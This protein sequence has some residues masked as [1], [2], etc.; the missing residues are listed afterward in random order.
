MARAKAEASHEKVGAVLEGRGRKSRE[1]NNGAPGV[2][3]TRETYWAEAETRLMEEIVRRANMQKA[4]NRVVS[5][6]GEAGV[7]S[8]S[9][10]QLKVYL[11]TDWPR[12]KEELLN[13]T[14]KPQPVRKVEIPKPGGGTRMLGNTYVRTRRSAERVMTSITTFL[15]TRLKLTVNQNKSAVDRPWKRIFLGYGMTYHRS[16]KLKICRRWTA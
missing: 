13:G 3:V 6:K 14:Y 5:N 8:M 16:H 2:T 10:G 15:E 7:D 11:Q 4:Y 12:I 9:T 1:H